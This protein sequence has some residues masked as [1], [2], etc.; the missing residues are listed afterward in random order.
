MHKVRV[1]INRSMPRS[2]GWRLMCSVREIMNTGVST[3]D[4]IM[5][6]FVFGAMSAFCLNISLWMIVQ[7]MKGA[8]KNIQFRT[9]VQWMMFMMLVT[10]G[11]LICL[12]T[13]NKHFMSF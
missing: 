7:W 8:L 3:C 13:R 10:P 6:D 11:R 1:F 5:N 2:V 4:S 12:F 9:T